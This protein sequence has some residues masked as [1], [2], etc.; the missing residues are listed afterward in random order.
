MCGGDGGV[1]VFYTVHLTAAEVFYLDTFGSDFD[2]VIRILR[3]SAC[4]A[5]AAPMGT[6]CHDNANSV[7]HRADAWTRPA[8][9]AGDSC[10]IID[11]LDGTQTGHNVEAARRARR[12]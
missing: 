6:H 5:G 1:D 10:I 3:G 2:T 11:G 12:A 9:P 8:L 4:T 7:Q